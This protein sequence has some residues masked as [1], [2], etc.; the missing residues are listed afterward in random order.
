LRTP[1]LLG[2]LSVAVSLAY[3]VMYRVGF[4]PWDNGEV[5][6]E[7]TRIIDGEYSLQTGRVLD[8]GCG[9][10]TEAVYLAQQGWRVTALD[11][12]DKALGR[13]RNRAAAEGVEV[14]WIKA[15]AG[16]LPV[17]GLSGGYRLV[18]D[19]G[20]FHGLPERARDP[21]ARGVNQL[22]AP[23]ATILIMCFEPN[24]KPFGPSGASR[25]ELQ[26]RFGASWNLVEEAAATE[27]PPKGPMADVP[28]RWYRFARS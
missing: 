16:R 21:Y 17:A 5:P 12:V 14:E 23:D 28:L 20:C 2:R 11:V 15:D 10:G 3:Q 13:A 9:S 27:G 19:R 24:R 22:A 6:R 1:P 7:L 25:E 8:I 4:T 26:Q 18:F